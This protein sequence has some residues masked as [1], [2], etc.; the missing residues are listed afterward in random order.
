M[1]VSF[2]TLGC[3][4]NQFETEAMIELLEKEGFE[5]VEPSKDSDVFIVN[6]CAVTGESDRKSKQIIK[7]CKKIN[8]NAL[9]AA[10]GCS[11]QLNSKKIIKETDVDVVIGTKNKSSIGKLIKN[12]VDKDINTYKVD[13]FIPK[14]QYEELKISKVHKRTRANIKIQDGCRQFCSYCIIPFVR[15][16]IR[17][18]RKDDIVREIEKLARNNYKEVILNGI[19]ISSY[20]EDL[21]EST[22]LADIIEE[23]EKIEGIHRIRL[24]SLEPRIINDKFMKRISNSSKL[25]DH[26]HLSLQSGSNTVLKRMNRKY[27]K[28]EYNEKVDIIRG[29]YPLGGITTDIIVGFPQETDSE[30]NETFSFIKKIGFSKVHVFKFS[31]REGTKAASLKGQIDGNIKNKRSKEITKISNEMAYNFMKKLI[32]MEIEVLFETKKNDNFFEGLTKN[33][34]KVLHKSDINIVNDIKKIVIKNIKEDCLIGI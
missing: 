17:S 7:K 16:P 31:P 15:G 20:G 4:V 12:K 8:P 27:T 18:R 26:F 13:N 23:I 25:C 10:V 22:T 3:K 2:F 21:E 34:L 14:E 9:V 30:F 28:E 24:G 33:Y 1:K 6:T 11:T 5:V 19:H 29:Y 32:G